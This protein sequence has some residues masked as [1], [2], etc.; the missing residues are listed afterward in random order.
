MTDMMGCPESQEA[1]LHMSISSTGSVGPVFEV[2]PE[3]LSSG[4]IGE[5]S[6][7]FG[8]P[9]DFEFRILAKSL[10]CYEVISVFTEIGKAEL[11]IAVP[12]QQIY[13]GAK[14][15]IP[16]SLADT[17]CATLGI[18]GVLDHLNAILRTS[19]NINTP[20]LTSLL[21]DYIEKN[22][23][24]SMAYSHLRPVWKTNNGSSIKDELRTRDDED[25]ENNRVVP[26]WVAGKWPIPISHA[27]VDKR[28]RVDVWAPINGYKWPVPIPKDANLDLIQIEMLNLGLEYMWLDVLCLRQAGGPRDNIC[29]EE[30][31][32]DVPTIGEV[33]L[34]VMVVIYFSGLGRAFS[35]EDGDLDSDRCWFRRAWTLQEVG[36]VERVIAG[37]MPDGPMHAQ[38]IDEDRNYKTGILTRFHKQWKSSRNHG[39]IFV[40]LADMRNRVSTNPVDRVAG[41]AFRLGPNTL[42]AYHESESLEDAWTALVNSMLPYMRGTF[43]FKYPEVGQGL[44]KWRPTWEQVMMK[45][46][47]AIL[48]CHEHVNRDDKMD[49]DWHEGPCLEKGF[50]RG[51][52]VGSTDLVD[53]HGE[54]AVEDVDG[55]VH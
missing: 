12:N 52:A 7:G 44:K 45:S 4:V 23:D 33:Y 10:R 6:D 42:L 39:N 26:H 32:L 31:M 40:A 14:P 46:L 11:S 36:L 34:A 17:P 5:S 54:L 28:N 55:T 47:P 49:E 21:E 20:S 16:S 15:V 22:Y 24:F 3:V 18:Q 53:R 13:T 43:L 1:I 50:V 51:L 2:V 30:W 9:G 38:P 35:L 8:G 48:D 19:H 25:H 41:L 27:W 29:A 37:D